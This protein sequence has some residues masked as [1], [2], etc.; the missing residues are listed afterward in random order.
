MSKRQKENK[1]V[2]NRTSIIKL[3]SVTF[4][5]P[6]IS[7]LPNYYK[8]NKKF[9]LFSIIILKQI[10]HKKQYSNIYFTKN[11]WYDSAKVLGDEIDR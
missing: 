6:C 7:T 3:L 5:D 9:S 4:T 8:L 2:S 1:I 11:Y 10:F